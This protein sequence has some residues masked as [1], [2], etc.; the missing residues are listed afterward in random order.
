MAG[1]PLVTEILSSVDLKNEILP[2][3]TDLWED[4]PTSAETEALDSIFSSALWHLEFRTQL[5]H[6]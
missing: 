5:T 2:T 6:S 4:I 1:Y 3:T